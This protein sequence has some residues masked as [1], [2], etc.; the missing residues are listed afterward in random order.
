MKKKRK[1]TLGISS[2]VGLYLISKVVD[3]GLEKLFEI[4]K[5]ISL[6]V[7]NIFFI[8][9]L[10]IGFGL[11]IYVN[12]KERN[13]LSTK[14]ASLKPIQRKKPLPWKFEIETLNNGEIE[15]TVTVKRKWT[16]TQKPQVED[17]IKQLD[18]LDPVCGK[19]KTSLI[20]RKSYPTMYYLCS[21]PDC[22]S[23]QKRKK[24]D[25]HREVNMWGEL[26]LN[27]LKGDIRR[28]D[29]EKYWGRYVDI[30]VDFTGGKHDDYLEP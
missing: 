17:F 22:E 27:Q 12:M 30:Y 10:V 23:V 11:Y 26:L 15:W 19:C 7:G 9:I 20:T 2:V 18:L 5:P 3:F 8:L 6:T 28:T 14:E 1:I 4:D 25:K 29:F 13:D 24:F 16:T 21:N